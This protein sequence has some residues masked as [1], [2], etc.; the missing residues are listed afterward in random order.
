MV[1]GGRDKVLA[2]GQAREGPARFAATASHRVVVVTIGP[3]DVTADKPGIGRKAI[4]TVINK[5]NR[6]IVIGYVQSCSVCRKTIGTGRDIGDL[7]AVRSTIIGRGN[8]KRAVAIPIGNDHRC[9]NGGRI[10]IITG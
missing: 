1:P 2:F 10:G 6:R 4:F 5:E 3:G 8:R 9:R 7:G